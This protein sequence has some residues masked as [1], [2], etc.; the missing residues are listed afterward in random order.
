M[1][2][3]SGIMRLMERGEEWFGNHMGAK[4]RWRKMFSVTWRF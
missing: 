1:K 4:K 3:G 2:G